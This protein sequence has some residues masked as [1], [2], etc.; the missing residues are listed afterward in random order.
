[1]ART[2]QW[3]PDFR[4]DAKDLEP[5]AAFLRHA[6]Y[7]PLEL[8]AAEREGADR[9]LSDDHSP[10]FLYTELLGPRRRDEEYA[11]LGRALPVKVYGPSAF[12]PTWRTRF[13]WSV[14]SRPA[15]AT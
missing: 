14:W 13:C 2:G 4:V 1:M 7:K 3:L 15:R 6:Q 11:M 5:F 10:L 12:R 8:D 9:V